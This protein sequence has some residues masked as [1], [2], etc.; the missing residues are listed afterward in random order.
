MLESRFVIELIGYI[1]TALVIISMLM[2]SLVR[3]R[4]LNICGSLISIIYGI[5]VQTYP[6][7]L[8][9][10]VL[11]AVNLAQLIR[12]S[13]K[14]STFHYVK[15]TSSDASVG[16]FL[17]LYGK[18]I[19]EYFPKNVKSLD[20]CA[21]AHIAFCGS[22]PAG[23]IIGTRRGSEYNLIIDYATPRYRD[24]TVSPFIYEQLKSEGINTLLA[25]DNEA[26]F[27][28]IGFE[29]HEKHVKL[30]KLI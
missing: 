23:I 25:D 1:G 2:T 22:E 12:V 14:K 15:T 30:T 3:L 13:R 21:E 7:V 20:A 6:T 19:A 8:L 10:T 28:K 26:Y 29:K 16:Y 9:N 5:L 24:F 27:K 17:E 18:D 4:I 11:I